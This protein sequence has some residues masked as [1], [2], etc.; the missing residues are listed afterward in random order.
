MINTSDWNIQ[1]TNY[2]YPILKKTKMYSTSFTTANLET[3]A[4]LSNYCSFKND[5]LQILWTRSFGSVDS[6]RS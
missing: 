2:I 6:Y 5:N 4:T 1:K 3:I